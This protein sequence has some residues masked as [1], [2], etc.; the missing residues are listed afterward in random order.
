MRKTFTISEEDWAKLMEMSK[1]AHSTP[2]IAL[3]VADGL[4]GRDFASMAR[5]RVLN[6]W[7]EMGKKYGFD[8]DT[9]EPIGESERTVSAVAS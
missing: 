1:T 9:V 4:A 7:K 6:L 2:V 8:G 3:S 5:K